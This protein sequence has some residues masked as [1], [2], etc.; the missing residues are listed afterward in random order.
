[1]RHAVAARL[2]AL[3][4]TAAYVRGEPAVCRQPCLVTVTDPSPFD[5]VAVA[6]AV[7]RGRRG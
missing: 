7:R 4:P 2:T 3:G 6:M 5:A 1:M